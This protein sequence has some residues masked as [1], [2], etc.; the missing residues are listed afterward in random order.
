MTPESQRIKIAEALGWTHFKSVAE[1]RYGREKDFCDVSQVPD[2]L[3]D[4]NACHEMEKVLTDAQAER[5]WNYLQDTDPDKDCPAGGYVFH[6][7]A[8]QRCQAFLRTLSLW[9]E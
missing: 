5:F 7:T 4:L 9:E 6:A 2:Y 1:L 8:P 3:N